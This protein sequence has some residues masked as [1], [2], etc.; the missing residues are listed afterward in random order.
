MDLS[1]DRET[2]KQV[3]S[4]IGTP[5]TLTVNSGAM[6]RAGYQFYLSDNNVWLT[7]VVPAEFI[8]F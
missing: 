6:H 5:I 4:R 8:R 2:S 3:G 1:A 7:D